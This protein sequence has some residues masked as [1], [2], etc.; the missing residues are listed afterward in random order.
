MHQTQRHTLNRPNSGH[1]KIDWMSHVPKTHASNLN[2]WTFFFFPSVWSFCFSCCQ[3][4]AI[5]V[6]IYFTGAYRTRWVLWKAE[7]N[8]IAARNLQKKPNSHQHK[9]PL[10]S[11][12]H[13]LSS[14]PHCLSQRKKKNDERPAIVSHTYSWERENN[15]KKSNKSFFRQDAHKFCVCNEALRYQRGLSHR[16]ECVANPHFTFQIN[17]K[18]E[19]CTKY[20][21]SPFIGLYRSSH[22][23]RN[24]FHSHTLTHTNKSH[25]NK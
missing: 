14:Q 5:S 16:F 3:I 10:Y 22:G 7:S 25:I 24:N 15:K 9:L 11:R 17:F 13:R 23:R 18:W 4:R 19:F 12:L 21:M 8:S 20:R 1:M 2:I 6:R